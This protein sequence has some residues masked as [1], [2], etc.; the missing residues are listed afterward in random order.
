MGGVGYV[1]WIPSQRHGHLHPDRKLKKEGATTLSDISTIFNVWDRQGQGYVAIPRKLRSNDTPK[2]PQ[3]NKGEWVEKGS[4]FKWPGDLEKIKEYIVQ[5]NKEQYDLY[6]CPSI[7]TGPR[8]VKEN[9]PQM[10]VLYADLDEV[11]PS[12][13]PANL[14]PSVAWESSPNRFAA[15]WFL[16]EKLPASE[17]EQLNKSLT[18]YLGADKGGWDLTQVLRIPGTRNFKYEGSPKGHLLWYDEATIDRLLIPDLP[19]EQ[20]VSVSQNTYDDVDSDPSRLLSLISSVKGKIKPFTLQLLIASDEDIMLFDRSEK[21]WELECQL[22]E[23]GV[24]PQKALE[25]VACSNW[26]KYRGRKDELRRLQTEIDKVLSHTAKTEDKPVVSSQKQWTSYEDLLSME[27][28][29]PE[30]M[31]E[32]VWQK[33]SHGMIAGEPKTYKSVVATDMAVAVASGEPFLGKFKVNQTGPVMYIQEENAPVLVKDRIIKITTTRG[34]L[35]GYA[36]YNKPYLE[37]KMPSQLPLH[38]LNNQGFDFTDENDRQFLEESIKEIRPVLI[39]FD[40]LYLML[41]G[42]DENSSKDIRP[43]LN[44]LLSIRYKYSTSVIV[45]H[46]WNKAG[47]SERGGQ[48]MLG[49]VLFHGWVESAMYTRVVDEQAHRIEVEREFRS[50]EKPNNL[51]LTFNFG[52]P[53]DTFYDVRTENNVKMSSDALIDLLV[54]AQRVTVEDISTATGMSAKEVRKRLDS[55]V[56]KGIVTLDDKI[57]TYKGEEDDGESS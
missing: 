18:Y 44:W 9:I 16:D 47:K 50:F 54:Q 37:V 39:I 57:Y 24:S 2:G 27:L 52:P 12:S 43:V 48:R 5:S 30:W 28:D 40:P 21:L 20:A 41:G 32:G 13:I 31:I 1:I 34:A 3:N 36:R 11:N 46:H 29:Q 4:I 55:L 6:W 23:Q 42:K 8:R 33:S 26:N 45:I 56:K 49:S 51:E 38:F 10:S 25:L 17:A 19:D 14:K 53:G 35:D 7:L 22:I 15:V